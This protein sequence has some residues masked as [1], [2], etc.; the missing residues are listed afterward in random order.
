MKDLSPQEMLRSRKR[1][2]RKKLRIGEFQ[3]FGFELDVQLDTARVT[4]DEALDRWVGFVEINGWAF[5]GGGNVNG[6]EFSGFLCVFG[7]GS[8]NVQDQSK[9]EVWLQEQNW[10]Q[11]FTV[12]PLVD[13]WHGWSERA[14]QHTP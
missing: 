1:R 12:G 3:E 2:L 10:I 7:R 11:S 13:A 8:L 4:F 5:G 9:V 6:S 14:A